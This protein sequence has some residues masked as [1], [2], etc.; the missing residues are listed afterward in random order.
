MPFLF[1]NKIQQPRALSLA[2]GGGVCNLLR[3]MGQILLSV[4]PPLRD[5]IHSP[6]GR[7]RWTPRFA[8]WSGDPVFVGT[9][10]RNR[11]LGSGGGTVN[12]LVQ[13][14]RD[15]RSKL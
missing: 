10:P 3:G 7:R 13:A 11:R 6:A 8:A 2:R 5:F 15:G 14:W 1:L 12:L 4:P 9:D